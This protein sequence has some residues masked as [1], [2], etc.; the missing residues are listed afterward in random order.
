MAGKFSHDTFQYLED[1][2]TK[3]GKEIF[4]TFVRGNK[5]SMGI[6]LLRKG[7]D[8]GE[9]AHKNGEVYYILKGHATLK[10]GKKNYEVSPGMAMNIPPKVH[11]RFYNVKKELVFLFIFGGLD[12]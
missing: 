9:P 4:K 8:Y 1:L 3:K 5:L 6:Q 7:D 11:H 10:I 12:D 2:R